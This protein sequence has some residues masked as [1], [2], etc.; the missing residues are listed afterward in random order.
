MDE[1]IAE[2][3]NILERYSYSIIDQSG[4]K[5]V[6]VDETDFDHIAYFII[7]EIIESKTKKE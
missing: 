4:K 2:I 5:L 3:M 7:E 1:Q 6:V